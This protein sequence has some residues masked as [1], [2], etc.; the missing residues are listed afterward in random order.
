MTATTHNADHIDQ[1]PIPAAGGARKG[2]GVAVVLSSIF[3]LIGVALL[4]GGLALIA[5]H[6]SERDDDGFYTSGTELVESPGYAV[7]TDDIDLGAEPTGI[8]PDEI[9]SN[10]R[11]RAESPDGQ[12]LF[13][14][15]GRTGDV[16]AYLGGVDRSV[17]TDFGGGEVELEQHAG[18]RP[19][20]TPA[21][22]DIWAAQAE[23]S[24]RQTLE[25]EPQNG[26]WTAVVMNADAG[27]GVAAD[28]D[29]GADIGWLIW[30]GVGFAAV[31]LAMAAGS[32]F[33]FYRAV[34]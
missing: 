22:E 7:T 33:V 28:M 32:G 18:G 16:E 25:W 29:A 2:N 9:V 11:L 4:L 26:S 10:L 12:A 24:G 6:G 21:D 20:G 1:T 30:V 5:I 14:G 8:A 34:R 13:L 27:R 31:G 17:A 23:G 3:G 19:A 15:V